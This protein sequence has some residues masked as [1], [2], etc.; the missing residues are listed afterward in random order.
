LAVDDDYVISMSFSEIVTNY[1]FHVK[2]ASTLREWLSFW[3]RKSPTRPDFL[4]EF[5]QFEGSYRGVLGE[6]KVT[7]NTIEL[8]LDQLFSC[9][10]T[11]LTQTLLGTLIDDE[12]AKTLYM[13]KKQTGE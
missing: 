13:T 12:D 10:S 11:R 6:Y 4:D 5:K 9:V 2:T 7:P 1:D 3:I 8:G